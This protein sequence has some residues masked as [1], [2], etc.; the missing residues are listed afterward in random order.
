MLG[1]ATPDFRS[2]SPNWSPAGEL[3]GRGTA[4]VQ[5]RNHQGN[6]GAQLEFGCG[7]DSGTRKILCTVQPGARIANLI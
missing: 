7:K 6:A 2:L 3:D 1:V 5:P 4:S